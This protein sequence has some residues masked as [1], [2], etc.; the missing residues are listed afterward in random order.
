MTSYRYRSFAPENADRDV[1]F[2]INELAQN[3]WTVHSIVA[4]TT[5]FGSVVG[6]LMEK[7]EEEYSDYSHPGYD[8]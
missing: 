6:V 1:G 8:R 7:K 3:G 5:A 2:W 4:P